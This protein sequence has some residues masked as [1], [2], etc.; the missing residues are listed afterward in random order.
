MLMGCIV[1]KKKVNALEG[2]K[3]PS[4][5]ERGKSFLTPKPIGNETEL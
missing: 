1:L 5:D 2:V 4:P 3:Y